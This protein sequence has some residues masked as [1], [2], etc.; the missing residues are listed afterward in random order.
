MKRFNQYLACASLLLVISTP[1]CKKKKEEASPL[2][3][4]WTLLPKDLIYYGDRNIISSYSDDNNMF[5]MTPFVMYNL[6]SSLKENHAQLFDVPKY[7]SSTLNIKFGKYFRIFNAIDNSGILVADNIRNYNQSSSVLLAKDLSPGTENWIYKY[8]APNDQS[9]FYLVYGVKT[10]NSQ[11]DI[12]LNCYK[13]SRSLS[14]DINLQWSKKILSD[15]LTQYSH[16]EVA[17]LNQ[18]EG[19][20]Y[21]SSLGYT[22][23]IDQ[24]IVTDTLEHFIKDLTVI[25]HEL[26]ATTRSIIYP[27]NR[28]KENGLL[29]SVD[30]GRTWNYAATGSSLMDGNIKAIDGHLYLVTS[31]AIVQLDVPNG[32]KNIEGIDGAIRTMDLFKGKV[33]IGTDAGVYVKSYKAFTEN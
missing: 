22:Y 19:I 8:T 15:V 12:Y 6:D 27:I 20:V 1:A 14:V 3:E 26:C 23:R 11:A 29:Q 25:D 24:G 30:N 31:Y 33:F 7:Y 10:Q 21:L 32:Q 2:K 17:D 13:L 9:V 28:Y 18:A 4:Q 16:S 5:F